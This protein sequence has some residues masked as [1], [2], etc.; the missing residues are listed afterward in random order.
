MNEERKATITD[1]ARRAGVST[2]TAG[3]VLGGYGYSSTD[4]K[5]RVQDA[6]TALGYSPNLLARSLITG[7]TRTI[8]F[9]AGDIQSPFYAKILR[10]ISDAAD[11]AGFAL[12]ITNSDETIEREVDAIRLLREKQVDG[13]IVS[14]CDTQ[15]SPHLRDAAAA[16][17]LVL[18]DRQVRGLDVDSIGVDNVEA[19]QTGIAR[20]IERGHRRIGMVAELQSTRPD[21]LATFVSGI[22]ADPATDVS[23]LYPSWQR[24][25]GFVRAHTAAGVPVDLSLIAQV[26]DYSMEE[27]ERQA[28]AM[29]ARSDRPSALFTADGLMTEGTM[30]AITACGLRI[31]DDLSLVGFDELD[32]MAFVSP[33][34]D[35]IAQPRRLMG[36]RATQMLI[37]RMD[38]ADLAPRKLTLAARQILRGSVRTVTPTG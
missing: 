36:Q 34:I 3:R 37:E 4:M 16:T 13:M 24:L 27:A 14:P 7:L 5:T 31:P 6:A 38:Q 21:E 35:A 20:L 2:A 9:V 18:I 25:A 8:G 1:V 19:V 10:G 29:L 23:T 30:H 33:G 17:P 32:W 11:E 26:G 28:R 22:C 12:L 15:R